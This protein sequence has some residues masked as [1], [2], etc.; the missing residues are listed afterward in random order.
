MENM[1]QVAKIEE[2]FWIIEDNGVRAFLFEGEERAMLVDTGFGDLSLRKMVEELTTLPVFVVNTHTDRDHVGCNREFDTIYM[3]PAEMDHYQNALPEGCRMEDVRPLWEGDVIDLG[4]WKFEVLLTPGHTPG[5]IM[6]LE[7]ERRMLL[8]G[9]T[10]QDG[11]IYMFGPGRNIWAFQ[12]TLERLI[13]L[14]DRFDT[15]WA[16]HSNYPLRPEIIPGIL[17]DARDLVAGKLTGGE[18]PHPM[19]CK[20]YMGKTAGFLY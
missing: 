11:T 5:S 15:I 1:E 16:C 8:S 10:V 4:H 17:A 14:S 2:H 18:L 19:P 13:A 7:R 3:H 9:D 20:R 6:L 12:H